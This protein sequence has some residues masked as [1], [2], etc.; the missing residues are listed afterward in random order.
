MSIY[1][2]QPQNFP[3][4]LTK[5]NLLWRSLADTEIEQLER[6]NNWWKTANSQLASYAHVPINAQFSV[7]GVSQLALQCNCTTFVYAIRIHLPEI[8]FEAWTKPKTKRRRDMSLTSDPSSD[9]L[10]K[11]FL[12]S[13]G[14][15]IVP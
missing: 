4:S 7:G 10:D 9:S 14:K 6:S 13:E 5:F 2:E 12:S 15:S 8:L 3:V 1:V 11:V